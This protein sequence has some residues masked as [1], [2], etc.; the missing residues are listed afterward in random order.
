MGKDETQEFW[1]FFETIPEMAQLQYLKTR[2]GELLEDVS[3]DWDNEFLQTAYNE[4]NELKKKY[5]D[6]DIYTAQQVRDIIDNVPVTP[7]DVS[8]KDN[9]K[10]E[11]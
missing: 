11:F 2:F 4:L 10:N 1:D 6:D 3:E 7:E 5:A 8:V 9:I